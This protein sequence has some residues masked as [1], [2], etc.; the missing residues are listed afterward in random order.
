[1]D[2]GLTYT[3]SQFSSTWAPLSTV[4]PKLI[5]ERVLELLK[6]NSNVNECKPLPWT[7]R[8]APPPLP[9]GGTL[10]AAVAVAVFI[11]HR[12]DHQGLPL[13]RVVA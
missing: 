13:V 12:A 1:M 10:S 8:G 9:G 5:H 2:Q 6:L 3:R 4:Q 7:Q 11:S